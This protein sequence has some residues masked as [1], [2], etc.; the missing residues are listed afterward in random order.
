MAAVVDRIINTSFTRFK[1]LA[2]DL[3]AKK[4]TITTIATA[5]AVTYTIAQLA[6][7]I[8]LR[9]TAGAIR[10]DVLPT[11]SLIMAYLKN[12][13]IGDSFEFT[14]INNSGA[15]NTLTLTAGTGVTLFGTMTV[16]QGIMQT[17]RV[18]LTQK[19]T[20]IGHL[21]TTPAVSVYHVAGGGI[22]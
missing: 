10:S 1:K 3:I 13:N 22:Y 12:S 19:V 14:V 20:M 21:P 8:I 18:V 15:A 17:F 5:G 9:D 7:G 4:T 2:A 11:A 6:G 16:A